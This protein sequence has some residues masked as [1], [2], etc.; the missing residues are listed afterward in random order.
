M[1]KLIRLVRFTFLSRSAYGEVSPNKPLLSLPKEVPCSL[2]WKIE[3]KS[4]KIKLTPS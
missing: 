1:E 3:Q 2:T 4:F